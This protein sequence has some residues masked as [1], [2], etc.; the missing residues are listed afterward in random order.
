MK[1]MTFSPN[2]LVFVP[3]V[4]LPYNLY[5]ISL[6]K[7]DRTPEEHPTFISGRIGFGYVSGMIQ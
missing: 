7:R 2:T 6:T 5:F 1:T 3:R 4:F